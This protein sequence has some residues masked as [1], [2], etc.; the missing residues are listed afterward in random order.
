MLVFTV[1]NNRRVIITERMSQVEAYLLAIEKDSHNA[2]IS[3]NRD[4]A[5]EKKRNASNG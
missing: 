4:A 2:F 3:T 5:L 1:Y